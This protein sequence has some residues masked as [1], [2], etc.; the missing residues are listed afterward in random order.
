VDNP[1]KLWDAL[2]SQ[3]C[4]INNQLPKRW[5]DACHHTSSSVSTGAF[6]QY[7]PDPWAPA[8]DMHMNVLLDV[9]V[10]AIEHAGW[11]RET[12]GSR[13]I[14]IYTAA[15]TSEFVKLMPPYAVS[16]TVANVL[17]VDCPHSN[18]DAACSSGYLGIHHALEYVSSGRCNAAVVG[19]VQLL[20]K[21]RSIESGAGMITSTT[22]IM[23][24]FDVS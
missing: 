19:A 16:H 9:T 10:D 21:P 3:Q 5:S 12:L 20:L 6:I 8:L 13:Q 17:R 2:V 14:C 11:S 18:I 23:R 1:T 4:S 7:L 15:D 22:G 24:P